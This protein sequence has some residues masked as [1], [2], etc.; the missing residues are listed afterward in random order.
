MLARSLFEPAPDGPLLGPV[1]EPAVTKESTASGREVKK[2][3]ESHEQRNTARMI[4]DGSL[5]FAPLKR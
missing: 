1:N 3:F 2:P 4:R 5:A